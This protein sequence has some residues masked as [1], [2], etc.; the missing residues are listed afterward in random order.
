MTRTSES[1]GARYVKGGRSKPSKLTSHT[2][3]RI[4]ARLK[5]VG[6]IYAATSRGISSSSFCIANSCW[7][8][9]TK[10]KQQSLPSSL[11]IGY[12]FNLIISP[13]S[14]LNVS[15]HVFSVCSRM[16]KISMFKEDSVAEPMITVFQAHNVA[17]QKLNRY[18]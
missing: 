9:P 7:R 4:S 2:V 5:H 16:Q 6:A 14:T 1:V 18:I 3:D 8:C 11:H 15:K 17:R 10:D 12:T 13:F